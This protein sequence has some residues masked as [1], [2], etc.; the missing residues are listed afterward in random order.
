MLNIIE[1]NNRIKTAWKQNKKNKQN[2][3]NKN[4]KIVRNNKKKIRRTRSKNK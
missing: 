3:Q 4:K 1:K 2:K